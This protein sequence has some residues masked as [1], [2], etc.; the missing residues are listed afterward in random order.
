MTAE[1]NKNS[2]F[3]FMAISKVQFELQL[4]LCLRVENEYTV[5]FWW[6][7][8]KSAYLNNYDYNF[9]FLLAKFHLEAA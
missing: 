1:G 5:N 9:G 6:T 4:K 3:G 7:I 2:A 8:F